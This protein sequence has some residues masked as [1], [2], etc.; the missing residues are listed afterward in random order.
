MTALFPEHLWTWFFLFLGAMMVGLSKTGVPGIGILFVALFAN[1][2]PARLSTGIVLPMLIVADLIAVRTYHGKTV[3]SHVWRLIPATGF[4]IVA[5]Y[6]W[7]KKLTDANAGFW[8]GILIF[9]MVVL[10]FV[11]KR[12]P[13]WQPHQMGVAWFFGFTGGT[14]TMVANA[15]GPLVTLYLLEMKLRKEEF[16][17]TGAWFYL[18]MNC[19]K[20]PFGISL[21]I[22]HSQTLL[23][24]LALIPMIIVGTW[25]GRRVNRQLSEQWFEWSAIGFAA[26]AALRLIL[27][28]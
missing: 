28:H 16:M 9:S 12:F 15:A 1:L 10:Y 19:V 11:R 14:V 3:W 26:V 8:I 17:G 4:G 7:M 27:L 24:N 22:I 18:I 20:V 5:G 6:F 2:F 21:G 13:N 25:V 23:L